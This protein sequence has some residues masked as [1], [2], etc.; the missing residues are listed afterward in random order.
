MQLIGTA[1]A[2]LAPEVS[3]A[4]AGDKWQPLRDGIAA[5]PD[6]SIERDWGDGF[7]LAVQSESRK[8]VLLAAENGTETVT[9]ESALGALDEVDIAR[10]I[11][12]ASVTLGGVVANE[13]FVSLRESHSWSSLDLRTLMVSV[14]S[15]ARATED[16]L[17]P[18][19][20]Q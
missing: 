15:L 10:A 14:A 12:C 8:L 18:S 11:A 5:V 2:Q 13:G 17:A 6:L 9:F 19:A 7:L 1:A 3:K 20:G 4:L 16:Y